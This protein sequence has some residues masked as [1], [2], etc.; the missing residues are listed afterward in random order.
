[1]TDLSPAKSDTSSSKQDKHMKFAPN[2]TYILLTPNRTP[3]AKGWTT[4]PALW[5]KSLDDLPHTLDPVTKVASPTTPKNVGVVTGY[6]SNKIYV[7]DVDNKNNAPYEQV[8]AWLNTEWNINLDTCMAVQTKSNGR[9]YYIHLPNT[10]YLGNRISIKVPGIE[11]KSGLDFKGDHGYVVAPPSP[12][13]TFL[14]SLPPLTPSPKFLAWLT[15]KEAGNTGSGMSALDLL[16]KAL[17]KQDIE[18]GVR[19]DTLFEIARKFSYMVSL[20]DPDALTLIHQLLISAADRCNPPYRG[21]KEDAALLSMAERV[22]I[23]QLEQSKCKQAGITMPVEAINWYDISQYDSTQFQGHPPTEMSMVR[24]IVSINPRLL[25]HAET[26]S[27]WYK[28]IIWKQLTTGEGLRFIP[29][30]VAEIIKKD[31]AGGEVL[32]KT[33]RL[34]NLLALGTKIEAITRSMRPYFEA[35]KGFHAEQNTDWLGFSNGALNLK[36]KVLYPELPENIYTTSGV[37]YPFDPEARSITAWTHIMQHM[38]PG[39]IP[40]Q[41][42]IP[43]MLGYALLG[44]NRDAKMTFFIG[45]ANSGKSLLIRVIRQI[46]GG[47]ASQTLDTSVITKK[48]TSD[49][50]RASALI[51]TASAKI[52]TASEIDDSMTL[53]NQT[54]KV[55]SGGDEIS[56]RQ[57]YA[58]ERFVF[59]PKFLAIITGND[60]PRVF[61]S[62]SPAMQRRLI[63]IKLEH[64]V[65]AKTRQAYPTIEQDLIKERS[66]IFNLVLEGMHTYLTANQSIDQHMPVFIKEAT[67]RF[68]E[69]ADIFLP[70]FQEEL[71][72]DPH[73]RTPA[74]N[75]KAAFMAYAQHFMQGTNQKLP[76]ITRLGARLRQEKKIS[77]K[78]SDS[79]YYWKGVRLK[80][81]DESTNRMVLSISAHLSNQKADVG[82]ID[83]GICVSFGNPDEKIMP[84]GDNNQNFSTPKPSPR[85]KMKLVPTRKN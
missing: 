12:G 22:L 66:A 31:V 28:D 37:D 78:S 17:V 19:D 29:Q 11:G 67:A 62:A 38:F 46:F 51:P 21:D 6:P 49:G 42:F 43:L 27:W 81:P 48:S 32:K 54:V 4:N 59:I 52:V 14:N 77:K 35:P 16:Y 57:P 76:S 50:D 85:E 5:I 65:T 83:A 70:F 40:M 25:W 56:V 63:K 41:D 61:N 1:M 30:M 10:E 73:T 68:L 60:D 26:G 53:H 69:E 72:F 36:T 64:A 33:D 13:Y 15:S 80:N 20:E 18:D 8:L 79:Q 24:R 7:I 82:Y 39:N 71:I 58:K 84:G 3:T 2:Q 34:Y 47:T 44:D 9:H 45:A 75:M 74:H 23:Y 55:L